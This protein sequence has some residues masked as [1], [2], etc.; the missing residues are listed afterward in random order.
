MH[1]L[2]GTAPQSCYGRRQSVQWRV[3]AVVV[4]N[5]SSLWLSQE[6]IVPIAI[7]VN[8]WRWDMGQIWIE[9]DFITTPQIQ[10]LRLPVL[11]SLFLCCDLCNNSN[12]L[13]SEARIIQITDA[14]QSV[15]SVIGQCNRI[16]IF[17][18][19][20]FPL[21]LASHLRHELPA[22]R[23]Q[24][25]TCKFYIIIILYYEDCSTLVSPVV[26]GPGDQEGEA[27]RRFDDNVARQ[28]AELDLSGCF[29]IYTSY[30]VLLY[31]VHFQSIIRT[32]CR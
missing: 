24:I 2:A 6:S 8:L 26:S 15:L 14:C 5:K 3:A 21:V 9:F 28:S 18:D 20:G 17:A 12:F 19:N 13:T 27:S 7:V 29:N 30:P 31:T 23:V 22:C 4:V 16:H 32:T 1:E 25:V 10:I 11:H